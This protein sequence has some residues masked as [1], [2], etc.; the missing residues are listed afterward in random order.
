MLTL[1]NSNVNVTSEEILAIIDQLYNY[2]AHFVL[3]QMKKPKAAFR[4]DFL[5]RRPGRD[6]LRKHVQRGRPIGIVPWSLQ[7]VVLDCDAGDPTELVEQYPPIAMYPTR[8]K[9]HYH[10]WYEARE[11]QSGYYK[12]EYQG[13]CSGEILSATRHAAFPNYEAIALLFEGMKSAP[14]AGLFHPPMELIT[15]HTPRSEDT[16]LHTPPHPPYTEDTVLSTQSE[17]GISEAGGARPSV[18]I[19]DGT[20]APEG[21]ET[22][23]VGGRHDGLLT[24]LVGWVCSSETRPDT[25]EIEAHAIALRSELPDVRDFPES[26]ALKIA[27]WVDRRVMP[28]SV[29]GLTRTQQQRS[30][31]GKLKALRTRQANAPRDLRIWDLHW[32]GRSV[33]EIAAEVGGVSSSQVDRIIRREKAA[34]AERGQFSWYWW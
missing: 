5:T 29:E 13:K 4:G 9:G 10:A 31:G 23:R 8:T 19:A 6:A 27:A 17:D 33:R 3:C 12:W 11:D 1:A 26:E 16:A 20:D 15:P 22:V 28:G 18:F 7:C 2:Q 34:L 21:L 30:N 14:S 32:A 24:A 25:I